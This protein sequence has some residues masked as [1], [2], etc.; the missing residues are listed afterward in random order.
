MD[1][2]KRNEHSS[3]ADE[4][5][6][7]NSS[8]EDEEEESVPAEAKAGK[9]EASSA[10]SG[11]SMKKKAPSILKSKDPL[12]LAARTRAVADLS[13]CTVTRFHLQIHYIHPCLKFLLSSCCCRIQIKSSK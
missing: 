1:E 8:D 11:A 9:K 13:S 3:G 7:R 6:A 5:N 12:R 2:L 10:A 4:D